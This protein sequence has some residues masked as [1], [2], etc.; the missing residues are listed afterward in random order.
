MTEATSDEQ[1]TGFATSKSAEVDDHF[2]AMNSQ[3]D[4]I[5]R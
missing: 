5:H 4:V 2:Y 3:R 1:K